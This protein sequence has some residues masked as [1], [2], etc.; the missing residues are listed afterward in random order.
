MREVSGTPYAGDLRAPFGLG[1]ATSA[2]LV[3]IEWPSGIV[4]ELTNVAANRILTIPEP[5]VV[6]IGWCRDKLNGGGGGSSKPVRQA[7]RP[8][9]P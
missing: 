8:G 4:Q 9:I 6:S 7:T 2:D 3:R 1:D 5:L